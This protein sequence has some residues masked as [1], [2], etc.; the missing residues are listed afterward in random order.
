MTDPN[1][2][3]RECRFSLS[4][5]S[6]VGRWRRG[7]YRLTWLKYVS[8][9]ASSRSGGGKFVCGLAASSDSRIH[10]IHISELARTMKKS[11]AH[12][13]RTPE[14]GPLTRK[15]D[16][17][18]LRPDSRHFRPRIFTPQHN[19]GL[20]EHNAARLSKETGMACVDPQVV[21]PYLEVMPS[22]DLVVAGVEILF[23]WCIRW[24]NGVGTVLGCGVGWE[25]GRWNS[26]RSSLS[27]TL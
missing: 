14:L 6:M 1:P 18:S 13:M 8:T 17:T 9:S 16:L 3:S 23:L 26:R 7:R 19:R 27:R 24:R 12:R 20:Q 10:C 21:H 15:D 22:G 2:S 11:A 5:L 4:P 25:G